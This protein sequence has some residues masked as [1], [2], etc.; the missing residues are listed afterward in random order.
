MITHFFHFFQY[1][2]HGIRKGTFSRETG[3]KV[4]I[5]GQKVPRP[6]YMC[7]ETVTGAW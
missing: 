5:L 1:I 3:I 6:T 2:T 4:T 7:P